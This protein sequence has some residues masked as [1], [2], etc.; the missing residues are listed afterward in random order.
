MSVEPLLKPV[1]EGLYIVG[2][3]PILYSEA[4]DV[5]IVADIHLGYEEAMASQG[6]FLPRLQL[7]KALKALSEARAIVRAKG[8][9]IN[10]DIKHAFE[11]LLKQ[12]RVE[13]EEFIVKL[14]EMGFKE[15]LFVRG[16]HDNYVSYVITKLGVTV[17]EDY[18][19]LSNGV[20]VTHGHL[21]LEP[22][23]D[24]TV[25]GHEHPAVYLNVGGSKI[26]LPAL[27]LIP[28]TLSTRILVIP[29]LG[30]YQTGNVVTL[31]RE[32]FLSP[33]V[34][35]YGVVGRA[36]PVIVDE[37]LGVIALPELESLADLL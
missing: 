24:V 32:M 10:G 3:K 2:S 6:V 8:V 15:I 30:V 37:S 26:K 5:F 20:R 7:R 36:K 29:A 28:T 23:A 13:V 21:D 4:D 25:I 18:L 22:R 12:E 17:V 19:D 11:R 16:N 34:R 33:M 1:V 31:N 14:Q 9:V 27:L 35:G